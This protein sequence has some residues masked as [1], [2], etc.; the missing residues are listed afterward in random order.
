M[1]RPTPPVYKTRNCPADNEALKCRDSLTIWFD[2][3]MTCE[4]API[5]RRGRQQTNSDA[6]MQT[7]PS[8]KVLI[9]MALRQ[10]TGF[11]ERLLR[12]IGLDTGRR[13]TSAR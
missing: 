3:E 8:M 5:V 12:L 13:P 4:A 6:A 7:C 11:V 9:G 10:R 1:S 2:P